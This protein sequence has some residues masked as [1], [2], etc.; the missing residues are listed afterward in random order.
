MKNKKPEDLLAKGCR[1]LGVVLSRQNLENLAWYCRELNKWNRKVN[2][3]ART[4]EQEIIDK[5]FL[6]SL[7][8][9]PILANLETNS[10]LDLG[11]GAGFPGLVLKTAL[12][13]LEL[14]LVEAR[15][16]KTTF[17]RHIIRNLKLT[18]VEIMAARLEPSPP[19]A[20]KNACPL[21]VSRAFAS[22]SGFL[23]LIRGYNPPGGR[24]ICMKG[25]RAEEEI[26]EWRS[27]QPDSPFRL[28]FIHHYQLPFSG[29]ERALVVFRKSP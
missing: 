8:L 10:M 21:I 22:I 16:K 9:L 13:D 24:V 4:G 5:H 7:A 6:D 20:R 28:H 1:D 2:L 19:E 3:I 26:E 29:A 17:L 25:P 18:N 27:S 15:L 11:T 23:D 14:L 12:P